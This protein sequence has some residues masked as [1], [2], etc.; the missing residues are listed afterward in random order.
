MERTGKRFKQG[1]SHYHHPIT[2]SK[3]S[4]QSEDIFISEAVGID[5]KKYI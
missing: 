1:F 4:N 5:G 2:V 3:K